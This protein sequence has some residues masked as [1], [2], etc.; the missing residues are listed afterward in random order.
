MASLRTKPSRCPLASASKMRSSSVLVLNFLIAAGLI[1]Y[2]SSRCA[3]DCRNA[4]SRAGSCS[5]G[6]CSKRRRITE[7]A[8]ARTSRSDAIAKESIIGIAR[9]SPVSPTCRRIAAVL[10]SPRHLRSSD[11]HPSRGDNSPFVDAASPLSCRFCIWHP[12]QL[13]N[14]TALLILIIRLTD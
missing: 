3:H 12:Y 5:R 4:S 13:S 14:D 2:Q 8:A 1:P 11:D 7:R 10:S 9:V 6:I